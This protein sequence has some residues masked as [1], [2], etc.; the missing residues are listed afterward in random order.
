MN[1]LAVDSSDDL[2]FV[3]FQRDWL[4]QQLLDVLKHRD[5]F[6]DVDDVCMTLEMHLAMLEFI[7][8]QQDEIS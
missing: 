2:A 8:D 3:R 4:V 7:R 1:N 5:E 6:E